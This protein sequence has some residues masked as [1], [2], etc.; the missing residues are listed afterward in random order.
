MRSWS[1]FLAYSIDGDRRD[2]ELAVE[3]HPLELGRD[4]GDLLDVGLEPVEDRRH[5][6]VR[7]T[8]QPHAT[9][10]LRLPPG[11]AAA[12]PKLDG[13]SLRESIARVA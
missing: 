13:D 12:P 2:V 6:H 7:D 8:P 3:Q 5:V 1:A 11:G 9:G 10:H 4:A